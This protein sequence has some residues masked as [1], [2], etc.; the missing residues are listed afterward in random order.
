MA[1]TQDGPFLLRQ[2][3]IKK[4]MFVGRGLVL[5]IV[6]GVS[7]GGIALYGAGVVILTALAMT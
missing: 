4:H 7:P 2:M 5:A 6:S 1:E 3:E